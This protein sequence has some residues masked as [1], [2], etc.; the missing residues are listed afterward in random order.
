MKNSDFFIS[1]SYQFLSCLL[2]FLSLSLTS[3]ALAESSDGAKE[4]KSLVSESYVKGFKDSLSEDKLVGGVSYIQK[5]IDSDITYLSFV[6]KWSVAELKKKQRVYPFFVASLLTKGSQ[7]YPRGV[8]DEALEKHAISFSCKPEFFCGTSTELLECTMALDNEFLDKGFDI[9]ASVIKEPTFNELDFDIVKKNGEVQVKNSCSS[10]NDQ[11]ANALLNRIFYNHDHPYFT[12]EKHLVKSIKMTTRDKLIKA[13]K[14]VL[15]ARRFQITALSSQKPELMVKK[16]NAHMRKVPGWFYEPDQTQSPRGDSRRYVVGFTDK[17][18]EGNNV[19][20]RLKSLVPGSLTS[21]PVGF[22]VLHKVLYEALYENIRTKAGLSYAPQAYFLDLSKFGLSIISASTSKPVKVLQ[23]ISTT[24]E[25]LK[26]NGVSEDTL[27][28]AKVGLVSIQFIELSGPKYILSL[29]NRH[30]VNYGNLD[31]MFSFS[32][33]V[34]AVSGE[35]IQTLANQFLK[36]YKLSLYG[37]KEI[38][39][40]IDKKDIQIP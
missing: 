23:V 37:K 18:R 10:N 11:I 21:N 25:D 12:T 39:A 27:H 3:I 20:V 29:M 36:D 35:T 6:L 22:Q 31:R 14:K 38:L 2:V 15:N 19:F 33:D 1:K 30:L 5:S 4:Q 26:E 24:L 8:I 13:Y 32:S 34:D 16:L 7:R 40:A 17:G 9:F 28:E